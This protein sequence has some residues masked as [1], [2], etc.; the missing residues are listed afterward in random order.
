MKIATY[1]HQISHH[2]LQ[3]YICPMIK[4]SIAVLLIE[5]CMKCLH[6]NISFTGNSVGGATVGIAGDGC[7]DEV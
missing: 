4:H 7:S 6:I 5:V 2:I 3:L 1:S